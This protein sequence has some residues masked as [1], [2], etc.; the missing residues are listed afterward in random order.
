MVGISFPERLKIFMINFSKKSKVLIIIFVAITLLILLYLVIIEPIIKY[1]YVGYTVLNDTTLY[2]SGQYLSFED[3]E[4]AAALF[5]EYKSLPINTKIDFIYVDTS[6][7]ESTILGKWPDLFYLIIIFDDAAYQ[8][9]KQRIISNYNLE[10]ISFYGDTDN[11]YISTV[12]SSLP[13]DAYEVS[14]NDISKTIKYKYSNNSKTGYCL[15]Y[16]YQSYLEDDEEDISII[17]ANFNVYEFDLAD[18]NKVIEDFNYDIKLKE[19][20]NSQDAFERVFW[21]WT[22]ISGTYVDGI[23]YGMISR[24]DTKIYYDSHNDCWL[25]KAVALKADYTGPLPCTIIQSDGKVLAVWME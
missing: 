13:T 25:V 21:N 19:I 9:E 23:Q 17:N 14:F 4:K 5:P 15:S 8:T 6:K 22:G 20:K 1:L 3:G 11:Y 24:S 10:Y 7:K 2:T 18:Y 12:I 16:R